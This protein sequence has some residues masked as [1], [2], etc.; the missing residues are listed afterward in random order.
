MRCIDLAGTDPAFNHALEEYYLRQSREEYFLLWRNAPCVLLGR[1]QSA[2]A[3]IDPEFVRAHS[4]AVIRRITGGGAVFNDL[5]NFNFAYIVNAGEGA[6]RVFASFETFTRPLI[7]ALRALG[8]DAGLSGRNDIT[9]QGRKISGNAQ[10]RFGDRILHHGTLLFSSDMQSLAGALRNRPIKFEGKAVSSV[11]A[12]VANIQDFL[13]TPLS[14]EDFRAALLAH[15][16]REDPALQ[17]YTPAPAE[18][19]AIGRLA[20][21]KYRCWSWNFGRSPQGACHLARKLAAGLVEADFDLEAGCIRRLRLTGDFFGQREIAG[22]ER[23]LEGAPPERKALLRRLDALP[24][25]EY[26]ARLTPAELC[27]LLTDTAPC[28]APA[29]DR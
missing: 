27:A 14:P 9:V 15:L 22:L 26:C 23:A 29:P 17:P 4:L 6:G 18:R 25:E 21:E 3:E 16:M 5:G 2:Y 24:L 7:G 19:E 13:T 11:S 12:R 10:A 28:A 1:N 8:V 20:D